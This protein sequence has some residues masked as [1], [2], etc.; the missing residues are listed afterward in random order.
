MI[1]IQNIIPPA[2]FI[3]FIAF[4][5]AYNLEKEKRINKKRK[6]EKM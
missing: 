2:A 5:S 6:G 4:L 1:W 3:A